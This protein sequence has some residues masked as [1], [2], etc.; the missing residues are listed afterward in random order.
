MKSKLTFCSVISILLMLLA[1]CNNIA[2]SSSRD[3]R[4]CGE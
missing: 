2:D 1:S 3:S 4:S